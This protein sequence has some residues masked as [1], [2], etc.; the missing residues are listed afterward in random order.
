MQQQ[1][2]RLERSD[3]VAT[4]AQM[5]AMV[6][7]CRTAL[8][9]RG[10][11]AKPQ[12]ALGALFAKADRLSRQ[13]A[14][15]SVSEDL[16][17]LM[18]S[19]QAYLIAE[20]VLAAVDDPEA[21]EAIRR[22][23]KSELRLQ[24][25]DPS[26]GKDALWELSLAALFKARGVPAVFKEP[27]LE[28]D[29]GTPFGGYGIACKKVYS[30]N[31]VEKQFSKGLKQLSPY[32]G[33]GLLAFNLD[34]QIPERSVLT[35]RTKA[36]AADILYRRNMSFIQMHMRQFSDAVMAGRCDGVWVST[37]AHGVLSEVLPSF[38]RV[39]QS[40]LWTVE[41]AG[42]STRMRIEVVR[43]LLVDDAEGEQRS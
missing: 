2:E 38:N 36:K 37:S 32:N 7:R 6:E 4:Y 41:G 15:G 19:D 12:S 35:S 22:V 27:D 8:A 14:E 40:T 29:L 20:A 9:A 26:Q 30:L 18:E 5:S 25:R 34:D 28:V 11:I 24:R 31:S 17:G 23:T 1:P 10:L 42:V 16:S 3:Q 13:W 33:A 43:Q 39:R 21:R